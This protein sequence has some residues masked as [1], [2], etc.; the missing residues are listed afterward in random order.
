MPTIQLLHFGDKE[1]NIK[2]ILISPEKRNFC[3]YNML[4]FS[5]HGK[6]SAKVL[7]AG[8]IKEGKVEVDLWEFN[9][10]DCQLWFWDSEMLRNKK[11][12]NKVLNFQWSDYQK[13][14]WGKVYLHNE[15][16]EMNQRW[17]L[18]GDEFFC[19]YGMDHNFKLVLDVQS[20]SSNDKE[21]SQSNDQNA[22]ECHVIDVSLGKT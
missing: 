16:G 20:S 3:L 17:S 18:R 8:M 1:K 7:Q 4:Y 10:Q 15:N 2:H 22:R 14:S 12:P 13:N 19:H 21:P 5:I 9:G 11:F 6:Q